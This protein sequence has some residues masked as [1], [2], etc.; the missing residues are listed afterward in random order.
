MFRPCSFTSLPSAS[1][2]ATQRRVCDALASGTALA[3]TVTPALERSWRWSFL[4][5]ERVAMLYGGQQVVLGVGV[6]MG[7][8]DLCSEAES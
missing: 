3:L 7:R 6:L 8:R 2:Q 5:R 4:V 1:E